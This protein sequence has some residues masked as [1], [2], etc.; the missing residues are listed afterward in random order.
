MRPPR[1]MLP[2]AP[3]PARWVP[4]PWTRGIRDTA[5]PV[6]Q[7]SAEVCCGGG[8]S[9]ISGKF[10]DEGA[11]RGV[12]IGADRNIAAGWDGALDMARLSEYNRIHQL[13]WRSLESSCSWGACDV[14]SK[15]GWIVRAAALSENIRAP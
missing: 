15:N 13:A 8:N 7:D 6:P 10:F 14:L 12:Q 1:H 2:N 5:R 3:C 4:P 11:S 9:K